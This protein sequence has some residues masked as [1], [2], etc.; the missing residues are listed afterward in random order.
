MMDSVLVHSGQFSR[1]PSPEA[2]GTPG[3]GNVVLP[4]VEE[5]KPRVILAWS[6]TDG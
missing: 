3:P 5:G 2:I 6:T 4:Q 1:P